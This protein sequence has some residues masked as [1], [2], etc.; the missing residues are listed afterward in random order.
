MLLH[1]ENVDSLCDTKITVLSFASSANDFK[2]IASFNISKLEVGSSNKKNSLLARKALAS[3][4]L[5]LSPPE[6]F[7]PPCSIDFFISGISFCNQ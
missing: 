4:I 7:F 2:I 1:I 6:K 5:C 3:P